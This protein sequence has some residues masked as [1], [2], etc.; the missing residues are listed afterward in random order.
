MEIARYVLLVLV[1]LIFAFTHSVFATSAVKRYMSIRFPT[2]F[3]YYRLCYSITATIIF[4]CVAWFNFSFPPDLI[5]LPPAAEK[6]AAVL[7]SIT[8][9]AIMVP[10]MTGYFYEMSGID[11]FFK[12][13]VD[14]SLKVDGMN[15]FVRH[16]LYSGTFLFV[17]GI[18]LWYPGWANLISFVCIVGY[19][20]V[21][22]TYE[23]M[24][25]RNAFGSQYT[26]YSKKV[27]M[28][29]PWKKRRHA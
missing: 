1:W 10:C 13:P 29:I 8:G 3:I 28:I 17:A 15:R 16:P 7:C 21:G 5:W 11:V 22:I 27:P 18:L 20:L 6:L 24:K 23:E 26:E 4:V 9:V 12:R 14:G 19:T 2:F 25:L